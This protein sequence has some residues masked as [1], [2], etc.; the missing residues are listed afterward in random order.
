MA[1]TIVSVATPSAADPPVASTGDLVTV[2]AGNYP[3]SSTFPAGTSFLDLYLNNALVTSVPAQSVLVQ[4]TV[5][6]VF[7]FVVPGGLVTTTPVTYV[8]RVRATSSSNQSFV[9][10]NTPDA[11]LTIIAPPRITAVTPSSLP[12]WSTASVRIGGAGQPF[13][14]SS[15]L[16]FSGTG[17][18]VGSVSYADANTLDA[19]ITITPGA[20]TTQR[21]VI[22]TSR[23]STI[24]GV[25]GFTVTPPISVAP[26][27]IQRGVST[28]LAI[29][30]FPSPTP[31][32]TVL[33]S[34]DG[35][36]VGT[37]SVAGS[38]INV[39]VVV[40]GSATTGMRT[41]TVSQNG[42]ASFGQLQVSVNEAS[43]SPVA[44]K[45]GSQV[46]LTVT[47]VG[48]SFT[49]GLT[50]VGISG[51]GIAVGAVVVNSPTSLT[52]PLTIA[53]DAEATARAVSIAT[54]PQTNSAT[55]TV[56]PVSIALSRAGAGQGAAF[57]MTI[58]G[59][60]TSFNASTQVQISGTGI[61]AGIPAIISPTQLT[62]PIVIDGSAAV[63]ARTVSAITGLEAPV[64]T[65]SIQP[66]T[67]T[68][69]S[70]S[71]SQG[72]SQSVTFTG[73][74]TDFLNGV[75]T[76]Q[77]DDPGVTFSGVS[78]TSPTS[79]NATLTIANNANTGLRTF[80]VRTG[81]QVTA[82][83]F[84]VNAASISANP[85]TLIRGTAPTILVTGTNTVFASG[86][87]TAAIAGGGLTTGALTVFSPTSLSIPMTVD[88]GAP[89]GARTLTITTGAQQ[90]T[91][92]I[93]VDTASILVT[94]SSVVPGTTPTIRIT[95]TNTEFAAGVTS[96]SLSGTGVAPGAVSVIGPATL[97]L[98]VIVAGD[99]A[100]GPRTITVTTG[101]QQLSTTINVATAAITTTPTSGRQG[102]SGLN[103]VIT[104]TNTAFN[105]GT[106]IT[107]TG[108]GATLG[109]P[110]IQSGTQIS[111]PL[112]IT[113]NASADARI[114]QV[115]TGA[116]SLTAPFT[117]EASDITIN[118]SSV[119]QGT[120][121]S[122]TITGRNTSWSAGTT[123]EISGPGVTVGTVQVADPKL[124]NVSLTVAGSA[125]SGARTV[126]VRSGTQTLS[127]TL[128]VGDETPRILSVVP[129]SGSP[130]STLNVVVT[131]Q[132]TNFISGSPQ[133]SFGSGVTVNSVAALS[134]TQLTASITI[135]ANAIAGPR[136]VTVTSAGVT[137]IAPGAFSVT[138]VSGPGPFSC[139]AAA[140]VPPL[141][142]AEGYTELTGDLVLTCTGGIAGQSAS[143]NL[144]VF[145]NTN[146]TSRRIGGDQTEALLI[147]D[148]ATSP[149]LYRGQT[150][151]NTE[152]A[153]T[154]PGVTIVQ[155][156]PGLRT[157]RFTNI[158][159]NAAG[160]GVSMTS[161]PTQVLAFFS[162]SPAQSLPIDN[163]QQTVGYIQTGLLFDV[164]ACNG[165]A[166]SGNTLL[167]CKGQNHTGE[168]DLINGSSGTMQ[169]SVRFREG[170]QTAFQA[171]AG[172][173]Q[174]GTRLQAR[175]TEIPAGVR[176]FVTAGPSYGSSSTLQASAA[177]TGTGTPGST[178]L[179][180]GSGGAV[181]PG[182]ELPVINGT[183]TAVWE[184][185]GAN[186]SANETALF[187]VA[188]AYSPAL[189]S[190]L[191]TTGA[192][193]V[194]GLFAPAY[195]AGSGAELGSS[196]LPV[197]R[198]IEAPISATAFRIDA[199]TTSLLFPFLTSTS[200][201]DTGIAIS[202]TSSDPFANPSERLQRGA[203]T[204]HFYGTP[205]RSRQQ[206]NRPV[207]PGETITMVLSSGG[208]AGLQAVPGFTGYAIAQCDFLYA[209]GFAF[210]TDGPIGAA[211]VA[212]G[213]LALVL[214]N[215]FRTGGTAEERGH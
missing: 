88:N 147:V 153:L 8:I 73:V 116:Q 28:T 60:N 140:G 9:T 114:L 109:T 124:L 186:P 194:A 54:G 173:D 169:Y 107:I 176:I 30:G 45:Q 189:S 95:G 130:G 40:A 21:D 164:R 75:T 132:G 185:T 13:I 113:Q 87:T 172:T 10:T 125:P 207:E 211:R 139:T 24:T 136:D 22:V 203:C 70:S 71:G 128:I 184:V 1:Q 2:I 39:P 148:E 174:Q 149:V 170:F 178:L 104:G 196:T 37:P 190:N 213:Y 162:A 145:L 12:A 77:S 110:V 146:I 94:P 159:A 201:F 191:P 214:D 16:A 91:A 154:W 152:N 205:A 76:V 7:T 79:L 86:V 41:V 138:G 165:D 89:T 31:G 43:I 19:G 66:P 69:S 49:Q 171:Q 57:T 50:T 117:I 63:G 142:R 129:S 33:I 168:R 197:P 42:I 193:S 4:A 156:G 177:F 29:T 6:R 123:V 96:V 158:R 195:S 192:A 212:E 27:A 120:S 51:T 157:L 133:I 84:T 209:H 102:D 108:G 200:G 62:V 53:P 46:A 78:V 74:N 92:T 35:L 23:A 65:L 163:P 161:I 151:L 90:L 183:A 141:L 61:T 48:T 55:F 210:I 127:G 206:T 105:N 115:V 67:V 17:I 11:T 99:A 64:A 56:T 58:N 101:S 93:Y 83:T 121:P 112:S 187:G 166:L 179:C 188:V 126:T 5:R 199:C 18:A 98:P 204:F 34:G 103:L 15:T 44:G 119:T 106:T 97:E 85:S 100:T 134:D 81:N 118:P 215:G 72:T 59:T 175:F 198:F 80:T 135:G 25:A 155:P 167:Q 144:Q 160:L 14:P 38:T 68:L 122:V 150:V 20:E 111:V 181:F 131:A 82:T 52:V 202:N 3:P 137:L 143:V 180:A 47:G 208:S 32:I 182:L 26:A 36:T